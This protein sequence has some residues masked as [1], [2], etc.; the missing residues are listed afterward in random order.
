MG[1][2]QIKI[3]TRPVRLARWLWPVVTARLGSYEYR[4]TDKINR[5]FNWVFVRLW[6]DL[7]TE[8][9]ISFVHSRLPQPRR[10]RSFPNHCKY[11]P[12]KL[13]RDLSRKMDKPFRMCVPLSGMEV[14]NR[15]RPRRS[16]SNR[17][18]FRGRSRQILP[19]PA[20]KRAIKQAFLAWNFQE[21]A[22][23]SEACQG[24]K[25]KLSVVSVQLSA[26][27]RLWACG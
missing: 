11:K 13:A 5:L 23:S 12:Y 15:I 19:N 20:Q 17:A 1:K 7:T 6:A 3:G 22:K 16:G 10:S 8:P 25:K 21:M 14:S 2:T 18:P 24:G 27:L 4:I 9:D 26:S